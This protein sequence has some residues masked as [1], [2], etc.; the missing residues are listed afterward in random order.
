MPA[1]TQE[2]YC[3]APDEQGEKRIRGLKAIAVIFLFA[4]LNA[5]LDGM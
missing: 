5:I 2:E 3:E 1:K 4:V